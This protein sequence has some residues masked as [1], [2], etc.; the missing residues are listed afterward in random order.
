M[1]AGDVGKKQFVA[2]A[3]V[4]A[5]LWLAAADVA[6]VAV[7]S[8]PEPA[9]DVAAVVSEPELAADAGAV[10]SGPEL[11]ADVAVVVRAWPFLPVSLAAH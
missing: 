1:S 5:D 11:A 6:V 3:A 2:G 8:E 10:V 9:A 4:A 7:V